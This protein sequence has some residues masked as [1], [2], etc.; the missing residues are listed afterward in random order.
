MKIPLTAKTK[1]D[2]VAYFIDILQLFHKLKGQE[3]A[4][5]K[6]LI[7]E[8]LY[9]QT[10]LKN[11]EQSYEIIFSTPARARYM[12]TLGVSQQRFINLLYSLRKKK[13]LNDNKL[14]TSLIPKIK[15]N[16]VTLT[17]DITLKN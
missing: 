3:L 12:E 9:Y 10:K 14:P 1:E 6:L 2:L 7:T 8:Y 4:L 17:F 13:L 15:D 16:K 11:E 5:M